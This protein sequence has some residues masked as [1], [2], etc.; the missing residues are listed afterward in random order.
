M[1]KQVISSGSS[2][3]DGTGDTLY[4][5]AN[6]I[7]NNFAEIYST[8][9]D[10]STL[11]NVTGPQ[12]PIGLQGLQGFQ[13]FTGPQG[14][15]G[16]VGPQG[17]RGPQGAQGPQGVRG[18]QGNLGPQGIRGPQGSAATNYWVL[19]ASGI[20]TTSNVG[21]GTTIPRQLLQVGAGLSQSMVVT[22]IGSV[23]IGTTNPQYN[24][25][26][27]GNVRVT[28]NLISSSTVALSIAMGL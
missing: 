23:G 27:N 15:Q 11:A 16:L 14:A 5:G 12:G 28:G 20:N 26:V 7:N 25:D 19:T 13:G 1:A 22:G 2:P 21:I 4:E 9:G 8:F 18:P 17:I 6:K 3:N 24:L 10:G